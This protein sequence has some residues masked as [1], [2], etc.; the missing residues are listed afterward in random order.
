MAT[1]DLLIT[2]FYCVND[3][4]PDA[5]NHNVSRVLLI[6]HT[7]SQKVHTGR[8]WMDSGCAFDVL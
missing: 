3:A 1:E 2:L 5:K 6:I 4:M 7:V 8:I